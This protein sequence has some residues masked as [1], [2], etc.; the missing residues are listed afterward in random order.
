MN[1]VHSWANFVGVLKVFESRQQRHVRTRGFNGN[2]VRIH[3]SNVGNDVVD[4]NEQR[5]SPKSLDKRFISR[6]FHA[7]EQRLIARAVYPELILWLLW[8]AKEAAYKAQPALALNM[9]SASSMW[10]ANAAT[11][12]PSADSDDGRLHLTSANLSTMLHRSTEHPDT[13]ATLLAICGDEDRFAI[14]AAGPVIQAGRS[15]RSC[16]VRFCIKRLRKEQ[17]SGPC[18]G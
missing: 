9:L 17:A 6:V 8:S 7:D 3:T 11:V 5:D 1:I 10:A 15:V 13:T 2:H 16:R 18:L 4:L 14:H 12:S